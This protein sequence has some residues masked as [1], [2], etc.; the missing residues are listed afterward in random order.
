MPD[1]LIIG[2]QKSG[3]TSA[4]H[5]LSQHPQ[6]QVAPQKEVHYFD[7]YYSQGLS[8]YQRQFPES[9]PE[10]LTGEA[11]PY[12][13]LHPDVPRR[14]AADF[15]QIKLIALLRNPVERAISH[16]YHAIKE[17]LETLPLE[18]ALAQEP[19]RL[20]GEAQKL[21]DNPHYHSY[22]YQH[23]SYLTRGYYL[24]QLQ[25]WWAY[26][27]KPQLLILHSND[28][29]HQPQTTLNRILDFLNLPQ[30]TLTEFPSLNSGNYSHVSQSIQQQLQERFR[31]H[32]Q[33]LFAALNQD[34]G[35]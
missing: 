14:V 2:A 28:L 8:W 17:G 20:A 5:Y 32:N 27:P 21:E 7:L 25:R 16:Y 33:R 34:W 23:H 15:P 24:Q 12:Y 29:Y 26:F 31:P 10:T 6:I 9:D 13:I 4:L 3:T 11:S 35:W 22:A 30:L 18:Q 1:F 19:T